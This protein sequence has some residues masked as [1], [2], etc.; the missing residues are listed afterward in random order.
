M[1]TKKVIWIIV[2]A[3]IIALIIATFIIIKF[4]SIRNNGDS[5]FGPVVYR[6]PKNNIEM[7]GENVVNFD[8]NTKIN[9]SRSF[10]TEKEFDGFRVSSIQLVEKNGV[11]LLTAD[12]TNVSAGDKNEYT[13][14]KVTFLDNESGEIGVINAM[15]NPVKQDETT[16]LQAGIEGDVQKYIHASNFTME[17]DNK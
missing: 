10:K 15:I 4:I 12:V 11:D 14:F 6:D 1:K 3:I 13:Y 16:K 9:V 5:D 7:L 17:M 2:V 8:E